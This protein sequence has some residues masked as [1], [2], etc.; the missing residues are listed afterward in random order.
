MKEAK[1]VVIEKEL[2]KQFTSLAIGG[3]AGEQ[4]VTMLNVFGKVSNKALRIGLKTTGVGLIVTTM[5]GATLY[6][7]RLIESGF[8]KQLREAIEKDIRDEENAK[9][10]AEA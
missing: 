9:K 2:F 1:K 4:A 3:I 7:E 6:T 10:T 8:E 5:I